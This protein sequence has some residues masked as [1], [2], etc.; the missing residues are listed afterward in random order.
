MLVDSHCHLEFADF[1]AE[2]EAVLARARRAGIGTFLT[3][4]TK[5]SEFAEIRHLAETHDDIWCSVG[6][7]PHE[8]AS[9]P[10]I[11]AEGIVALARHP[12]VIGIGESGLDFYY[13]HTPPYRQ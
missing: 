10:A 9:E 5:I 3:I 6:I 2:R 8:A 12:R 13:K 1:G 7:H 11:D 4:S